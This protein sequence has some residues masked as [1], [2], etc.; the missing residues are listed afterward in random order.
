MV[1]ELS[2][3]WHAGSVQVTV[4]LQGDNY[5]LTTFDQQSLDNFMAAELPKELP[6]VSVDVL[7]T[8]RDP[9]VVT[10]LVA[11]AYHSGLTNGY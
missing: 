1:F 3:G 7:S 8:Q 11:A 6:Q 5:P 9:Q 10:L 2:S 4:L